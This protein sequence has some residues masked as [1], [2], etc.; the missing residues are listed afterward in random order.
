MPSSRL[1]S[2]YLV[3]FTFGVNV[4]QACYHN[5]LVVQVRESATGRYRNAECAA[6]YARLNAVSLISE[7]LKSF[8]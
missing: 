6:K 4:T 3:T 2:W 7:D 5:V 1:V 8:A